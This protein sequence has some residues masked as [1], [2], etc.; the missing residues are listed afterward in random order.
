MDENASAASQDNT[1]RVSSF[2][3]RAHLSLEESL[4]ET[5]LRKSSR[6]LKKAVA[7]HT[8]RGLNEA[9]DYPPLL[10]E[11]RIRAKK[12]VNESNGMLVPAGNPYHVSMNSEVMLV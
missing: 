9:D 2:K 10:E 1:E 12:R 6:G 4:R 8:A 5:F 3:S 11:N 7:E